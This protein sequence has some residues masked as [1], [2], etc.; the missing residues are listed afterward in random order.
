M[1][2]CFTYCVTYMR[3]HPVCLIDLSL[4]ADPEDE[5]RS[6]R[7]SEKLDDPQ[8]IAYKRQVH[9]T[10][11][12]AIHEFIN[13][14]GRWWQFIQFKMAS[15]RHVLHQVI[16]NYKLTFYEHCDFNYTQFCFSLHTTTPLNIYS[17]Y[18]VT[19]LLLRF[20]IFLKHFTVILFNYRIMFL[21]ILELIYRIDDNLIQ[22]TLINRTLNQLIPVFE[23]YL[24]CV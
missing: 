16:L 14:V 3:R 19:I 13:N 9:T 5:C 22:K 17:F 15:T 7:G 24:R 1:S 8:T 20:K 23:F 4:A 10:S 6:G 21:I 11:G 12:W 2:L 18:K